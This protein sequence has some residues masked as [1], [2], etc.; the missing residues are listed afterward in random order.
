MDELEKNN[1]YEVVDIASEMKDSFLDY[2]MSVIVQRALPDVRDGLKPVHRRIL[3]AMNSLNMTPGSAHKKSARIVG[4]V[5]GKY[6]PHGDTAVYDSMV[7][8]AQ[9]F[10]Y[11]YP[12]VDG[13]GNF[14]SLDGDEA[15]AM[16]YTEARMSRISMEMMRDINKDTVDFVDNYD[17]EEKEPVVLPSRIP[18]LLVN[19]S[20]GIAVGMA[21]NIPPHNL[22][23]TAEAVCAY[24]DNPDIT[25]PELMEFLPGP[26]FPTGGIILGR[27]GIRQAYET[28]RGSLQV[29]SRYRVEELTGGRKRI[30]FYEIP[31]SVN[32][33]SLIAKMAAL[34]RDKAIQGV[35]YLND[36]SNREGIRIVMDLKKDAQEDVIL[37]QLFHLTPLQ[38]G[39][40]IN[41]L[42]LE[43]GRPRQLSLKEIIRDYVEHQVEVIRRKT[44]FDLKKAQERAHI[45]EGLRIA[46]DHLDEIITTIRNSRSDEAGLNAELCEKF[47]F[48][49]EQS[50]AILAMQMKR[51]S[52][53]ERDKIE[54]EYDALIQAIEDYKDILNR[55]ERVVQIIKDDLTEI[56]QKYGDKRRTE[57]ST[58]YVDMDDEDL[59]PRE[60]VI[61]TMTASGYIKR[62]PVSMYHAQNRGGKGI[63][64]LTLN[65]EDNVEH[66]VSMST[67]SHLLLFTNQGRVYRLKGYN[68]PNA[69]RTA[70]GT[71]IVNVMDLQPGESI[72]TLLPVSENKEG[73]KSLI[74]VT[75]NGVVKR[76]AVGEFDSI[77]RNGKIAIGLRPDDELKFVKGTTGDDDVIIAGSKGKAIRFHESQIRMM[78]RTAAGV[79]GFNTDGGEV[80]G[81]ALTH[82]GDTL[83]SVSE[84]GFGKRTSVEEFTRRSRGGK[85]MYAIHMTEKTGPLVSVMAVHGDEDAMIVASDGIMI[86][87]SLKDVGLY[88]RQTQGLKLINLNDGATVTRL[89][90]VHPEDEE[91]A[92]IHI[93]EE[94]SGQSEQDELKENVNTGDLEV[95]E[96]I[97]TGSDDSSLE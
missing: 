36:E 11:R 48:S 54:S 67:H 69:S 55:E 63:K 70:K 22:K 96:S 13:H 44:A 24:M 23:E 60:H 10:S 28:G 81:L 34:I 79:S 47:G 84:N 49:Y 97:E 39:F 83:L 87:I 86:R 65:D 41:M 9:D 82:E 64:S 50:R 78:G 38:S 89:S 76:T 43:G 32:K 4:E 18:N 75:R 16:R 29:R 72:R 71:P 88:S 12:L 40:G 31:F 1:G 26:D 15:A 93:S 80:V 58:D 85:G 21:T 20:M 73:F 56:V 2:S 61:I 46:L 35:T 7:R 37:N 52:G 53:L 94:E 77:N 17:G 42:A 59:I 92:E 95:D 74:F 51:L 90:L 8:M 45:L 14:G 5:I 66:M 33:A 19:G 6:H 91:L 3:H 25:I 30:V 68:I 57:I 62:Q 27:K